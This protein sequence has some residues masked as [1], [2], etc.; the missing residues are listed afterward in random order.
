MMKKAI[1]MTFVGIGLL[2][3]GASFPS[4]AVG[5]TCLANCTTD[6]EASMNP[7]LCKKRFC[8]ICHNQK[9]MTPKSK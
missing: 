9:E 5:P 1:K 3:L 6:C 4:M 8:T 2:A 7:H